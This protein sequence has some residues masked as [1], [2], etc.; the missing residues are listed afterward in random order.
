MWSGGGGEFAMP[1]QLLR[2][3][4]AQRRVVVDDQDAAKT[5]HAAPVPKLTPN[6]CRARKL[7]RLFAPSP[8]CIPTHPIA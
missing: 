2:Q 8:D 1:L 3:G 5:A 6:A 4:L 7:P